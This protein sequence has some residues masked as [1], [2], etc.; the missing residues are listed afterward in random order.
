MTSASCDTDM[1]S[2]AAMKS[3][4]FG[5]AAFAAF[6]FAMGLAG[7]DSAGL[8]LYARFGVNLVDVAMEIS[9]GLT[10]RL[11]RIDHGET[12]GGRSD[13]EISNKVTQDQVDKL[14]PMI[15]NGSQE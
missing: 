14:T 1:P 10:W 13:F 12:K 4:A 5:E 8:R 6:A 9:T 2:S 3:G 11:Y 15:Y 7:S